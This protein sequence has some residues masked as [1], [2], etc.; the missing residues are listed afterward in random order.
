MTPLSEIR[1]HRNDIFKNFFLVALLSTGIALVVN[2]FTKD[3]R[4]VFAFVP[5]GIFV[6]FVAFCYIREFL[7]CSKFKVCVE[8]VLPVDKNNRIIKIERFKFSEDLY[9]TVLSVLAENKAYEKIWEEAFTSGVE[10]K[11]KGKEFVKEFLEYQ[12][13]YWISLKLNSYFVMVDGQ[14]TDKIRREQIPNVLIKNRVIDLIS[15][16]IEEREKFQR[17]M[18]TTPTNGEL[19]YVGGEDG[20]FYDRLEIELPRNSKVYRDGNELVIKNRSFIIKFESEFMGFGTVLPRN[21]ERFYMNRSI[22]DTHNYLVTLKMSI[23]L[24]PLFLVSVRDWKYL[25]WLDQIGDKFVE[26][27]SLDY[28]VERI[29]YE[30]A[31]TNHMLFINGLNYKESADINSRNL[32]IVKVNNKDEV[33]F[34]K[35]N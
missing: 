5:G 20:V 29:G 30:K 8:T 3:L 24:K 10:K 27:F 13:V 16:P 1:A 2:A 4:M 11:G 22:K 7:G 9:K 18:R 34:D 33:E 32:R 23:E 28:F 14:A 26:Y 21:F 12:F 6:L 17:V 35:N 19:V 25:G 15:K 31:L